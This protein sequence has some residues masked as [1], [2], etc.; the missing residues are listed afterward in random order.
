MSRVT[1]QL[2]VFSY[3]K[4]GTSLFLHVMTKVSELLGLTLVNHYGM[5]DRLDPE[6]DAVLLPHSLLRARIDWPYRAIRMIRD[7]R[8]IWVSGYLYHR[9]CDEE[10]C[11][12]TNM[13]LTPP[14]RWP[15][16]DHAFA[17]WSEDWKRGYLERLGGKSYQ[18]NLLDRSVVEG[19]DFEL[20]GYTRCTLAAMREW[21][22]NVAAALD[23]KLED[24]MADFDGIMLRIFDHFGFTEEQ[25][26]AALDVARSEDLRRMDEATIAARPQ[27]HSRTISKWRDILPTDHIAKFEASHGDLIRR[28]GYEPTD[29]LLE[30]P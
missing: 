11:I 2:I 14:I 1:P 13:D 23:V 21:D 5:V 17:H 4:T 25:S 30:A 10:W 15:R 3:H 27:I 18:R 19:L 12:N 29:R 7:P 20:E 8:D 16:V 9:H 24:L 26:R 22:E 6:P 28:L